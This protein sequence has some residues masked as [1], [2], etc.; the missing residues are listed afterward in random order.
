[1]LHF[2]VGVP[3]EWSG[4]DRSAYYIF[5]ALGFLELLHL[6][7]A[8]PWCHDNFLGGQQAIPYWGSVPILSESPILLF[9]IPQLPHGIGIFQPYDK[10]TL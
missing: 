10:V 2:A 5:A 6:Y 1:M 3:R 8:I 4:R 9:S 7:Q